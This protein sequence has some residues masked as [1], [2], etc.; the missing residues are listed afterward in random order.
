MSIL[1]VDR[2]QKT[3]TTHSKTRRGAT[4]KEA[5]SIQV[6][7][8]VS[9]EIQAGEIFTLLGPSG[10]GKSTTLRSV[11]GLETPDEGRIGISG[12]T[13]FDGSKKLSL[14]PQDRHLSMVF[15]SYAI[16]P[17]LNVFKNVSFPLEVQRGKKKV[18]RKEISERV[19]RVLEAVDLGRYID[20]SAVKLSGGQQQRLALARAMVT[21]PDLLLLDEPLSNLDAKLRES[22]RLE[23]KKLQHQLGLTSI[24][25]THDQGEAL[26]MS[27]R[28]AVMNEGRIVQIGTPRE[29][30]QNP[31]SPFVAQFVGTSNVLEGTVT[32]VAEGLVQLMTPAGQLSTATHYSAK[33]GDEVTL[34]IRPE[35]IVIHDAEARSNYPNGWV[36]KVLAGAYVGEAVDYIADVNG[37]EMR[38]RAN[39]M[40][41]GRLD[42]DVFLEIDPNRV[43]MIPPASSS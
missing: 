21:Q 32:A 36:G 43:Y 37:I 1:T 2:L 5:K 30:Y 28:I 35:D 10:C 33:V 8:D 27:S 17:H 9:F 26:A 12:R 41:S 6:L 25:V 15:Q 11:A 4:A 40:E 24:Y 18:S 14:D 31:N 3:F 22:M 34:L 20:R 39:P 23:L 42:T 38:L 7:K 13:V 29:I 19:E 16:W